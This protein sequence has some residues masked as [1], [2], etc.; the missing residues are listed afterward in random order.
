MHSLCIFLM[1]SNVLNLKDGSSGPGAPGWVMGGLN[2]VCHGS[3]DVVCIVP[4]PSLPK[5]SM[6]G[7]WPSYKT[8][9]YVPASRNFYQNS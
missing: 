7:E 8:R 5:Q 1:F 6:E 4:P 2:K 3:S 9:A